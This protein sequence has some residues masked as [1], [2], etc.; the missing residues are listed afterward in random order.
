M[1]ELIMI[2]ILGIAIGKKLFVLNTVEE[3]TVN[4][5]PIYKPEVSPFSRR[6]LS[7]LL[8]EEPEVPPLV[9]MEEVR[10]SIFIRNREDIITTFDEEY[11]LTSFR[12]YTQI[13]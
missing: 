4:Y 6:K 10:Q 5:K 7:F 9:Y 8:D 2:V 13:A 11:A 12:R 1:I 3:V